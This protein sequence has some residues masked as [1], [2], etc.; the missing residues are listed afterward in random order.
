MVKFKNTETGNVL[1]VKNEKTIELME[2]SERYVRVQE[3]ANTG[4]KSGK[5]K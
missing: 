1:K 2:K 3:T 5:A 4:K